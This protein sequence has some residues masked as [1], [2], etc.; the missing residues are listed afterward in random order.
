LLV[1]AQITENKLPGPTAEAGEEF[2]GEGAL[3]VGVPDAEERSNA[4]EQ[5]GLKAGAL[6]FAT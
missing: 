2:A 4:E 6:G 3:E 1:A 5:N